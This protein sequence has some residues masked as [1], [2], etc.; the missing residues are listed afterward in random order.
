MINWQLLYSQIPNLGLGALMTLL[1][2]A[3]AVPL[4]VVAGLIIA[5]MRLSRQRWLNV[6]AGMYVA[7][8]RGT[9]MLVQILLFYFGIFPG[10]QGV[11]EQM[12]LFPGLIEWVTDKGLWAWCAG[13]TAMSLNIGAYLGETFRGGIQSIDKGQREAAMSLGM[14]K[15]QIMRHVVLPQALA[16]SLPAICNEFITI[17]KDSSLLS[18]IAV[19]ELLYRASL[20]AARTYDYRTMY[21]GIAIMYFIMTYILYKVMHWVENRMRVGYK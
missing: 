14:N 12:G 3:I 18:A 20:V 1:I 2:S 19:P 21:L 8:I 7:A 4:G 5:M 17:V 13:I 6:P 16:N 9:P 15:Y 11:F 10:I